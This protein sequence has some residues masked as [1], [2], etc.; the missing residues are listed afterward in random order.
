MAINL[1]RRLKNVRFCIWILS[2]YFSWHYFQ[3][4]LTSKQIIGKDHGWSYFFRLLQLF[5]NLTNVFKFCSQ[6][7]LQHRSKS[8]AFLV[9]SMVSNYNT[10]RITR[11]YMISMQMGLRCLGFEHFSV[12]KL[13]NSKHQ[14]HEQCY[15]LD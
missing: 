15:R 8:D 1:S 7:I 6:G 14:C 2:F 9:T 5:S 13:W 4:A 12:N 10:F 11:W 3:T